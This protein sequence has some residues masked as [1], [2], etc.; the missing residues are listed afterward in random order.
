MSK[1][2]LDSYEAMLRKHDWYYDYSDD[3]RA[4]RKGDDEYQQIRATHAKLIE[5][6]LEASAVALFRQYMPKD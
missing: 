4:Y 5:L 6:G 2:L 1:D 3:H